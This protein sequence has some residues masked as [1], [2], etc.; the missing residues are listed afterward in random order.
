MRATV[1]IGV[2]SVDFSASD[3]EV[4]E[5]ALIA[6]ADMLLYEAKRAGRNSIRTRLWADMVST[7]AVLS[8]RTA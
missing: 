2:L 3:T 4:T 5:S 1:S 8:M 6:A 7:H